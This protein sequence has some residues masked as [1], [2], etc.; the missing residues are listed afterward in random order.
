MFNAL[1]PVWNILDS[2]SKLGRWRYRSWLLED[3]DIKCCEGWPPLQWTPAVSVFDV[4]WEVQTPERTLTRERATGVSD[5]GLKKDTARPVFPQ[6]PVLPMRWTYSSMLLGRSKFTTCCTCSMSRPLA[7]TDVATSTGHWPVRKSL[8]AF[9]RSRCSR[10][11]T[12]EE[13]C[14]IRSES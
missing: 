5:S 13:K 11:L 7:A 4:M 3:R 9:S 8:S 6:R 12:R 2:T 14:A 10:S 1:D